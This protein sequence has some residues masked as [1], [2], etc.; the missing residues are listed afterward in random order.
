VIV[1]TV[2]RRMRSGLITHGWFR[3]GLMFSNIHKGICL[4]E[5]SG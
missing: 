3:Q 1:A 2:T 5:S 4:Y